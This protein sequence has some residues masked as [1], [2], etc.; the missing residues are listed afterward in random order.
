MYN[1]IDN[2]KM[3]R[4]LQAGITAQEL[5]FEHG[6]CTPVTIVN[7]AKKHK[8]GSPWN[9]KCKGCGKS[10]TAYSLAQRFCSMKC[11]TPFA[12]PDRMYRYLLAQDTRRGREGTV[13]KA[14]VLRYAAQGLVPVR[15][16]KYRGFVTD[17]IVWMVTTLAPYRMV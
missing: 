2:A 10:Y 17:N 6:A 16:S 8:G 15:K 1:D 13:T 12:N 11:R 5:A 14:E 3:A 7:R 4:R 9:L